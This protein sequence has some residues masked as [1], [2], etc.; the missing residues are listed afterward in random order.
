[1]L[2]KPRLASYNNLNVHIFRST[3]IHFIDEMEK[4]R[5][6]KFEMKNSE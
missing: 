3:F 6:K 2:R 4:F 1:M 5:I